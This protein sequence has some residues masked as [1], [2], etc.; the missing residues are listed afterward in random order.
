[1]RL[2]RYMMSGLSMINS[3][4]RYQNALKWIQAAAMLHYIGGAFEPEHMRAI[5]NLAADALS[6][7][8]DFP[9]YDEKMAGTRVWAEEFYDKHIR[10]LVEEPEEESSPEG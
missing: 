7:R 1:M 4:Y 8:R 5:G 6:G 9:D 3:E 10:P 2:M